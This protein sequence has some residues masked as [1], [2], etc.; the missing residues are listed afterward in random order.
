MIKEF[1]AIVQKDQ[2]GSYGASGCVKRIQCAHTF[3]DTLVVTTAMNDAGCNQI[4]PDGAEYPAGTNVPNGIPVTRIIDPVHGEILVR[5]ASYDAG[6][7]TCNDCC[8][9]P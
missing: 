8:V 4:T 1:S 6:R 3:V 2:S 5:T 7:A 9:E